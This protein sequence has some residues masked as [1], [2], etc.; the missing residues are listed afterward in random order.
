MIPLH[1]DAKTKFEVL[2][3]HINGVIYPLLFDGMRYNRE[4]SKKL[5][6]FHYAARSSDDGMELAQIKP[7]I[8]VNHHSDILSHTELPMDSIYNDIVVDEETMI[9]YPGKYISVEDY[10][11]V[12]KEGL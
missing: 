3:L 11:K 2:H 9:T 10:L 8:F 7:N 12:K 5:G 4:D 6:L 1:F